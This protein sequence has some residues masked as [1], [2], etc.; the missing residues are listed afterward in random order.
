MMIKKSWIIGAGLVAVLGGAGAAFAAGAPAGDYIGKAKAK[1]IALQAVPGTVTDVDL[2]RHSGTVYYEV[3]IDR[4]ED[5]READVYIDAIS[6]KVL[7]IVEDDDDDD[8][9]SESVAEAG[10]GAQGAQ[11]TNGTGQSAAATVKP[12]A[13]A[14]G[15]SSASATS[16]PAATTKPAQSTASSDSKSAA[17]SANSG[18]AATAANIITVERAVE[19]AKQAVKGEL[20]RV[21]TERDDGRLEYEVKLKTANGTAEVE[22][23]ASSGKV[24]DIDY[25]NDRDDWDD[26]DDDDWDDDDD[27]DD[28]WDD[29]DQYDD[30]RDDN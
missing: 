24:L 25:D 20:I 21:E 29:D 19:I 16:K 28:D 27:D 10:T 9:R 14:T 30:D 12:S 7:R 18:S 15:S 8:R 2:E 5:F 6:G 11:A 17:G 22:I 3:D 23:A 13:P 4:K 1:Q 26:D